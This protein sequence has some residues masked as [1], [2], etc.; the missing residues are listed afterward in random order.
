M[1]GRIS[2]RSMSSVTYPFK[3]A[4]HSSGHFK[5]IELFHQFVSFKKINIISPL[6]SLTNLYCDASTTV[7]RS[8]C[9]MFFSADLFF[10]E[11]WQTLSNDLKP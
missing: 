7:I 3:I 9:V 11:T 10:G 6:R 8:F 4:F 2:D 1:K 5:V